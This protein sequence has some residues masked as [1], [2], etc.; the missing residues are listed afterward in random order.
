[1]A[2][3]YKLHPKINSEFNRINSLFEQ[4]QK[5]GEGVGGHLQPPAVRDG[6]PKIPMDKKCLFRAGHS[7]DTIHYKFALEILVPPCCAMCRWI[8]LKKNMTIASS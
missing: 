3:V 7:P 4:S 5:F 6:L 8:L 2:E 1:M